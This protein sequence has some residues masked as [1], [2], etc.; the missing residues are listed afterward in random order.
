[1]GPQKSKPEG[2]IPIHRGYEKLIS[3]Q[4]AEIIYDGT[5][6]CDKALQLCGKAFSFVGVRRL[7]L[8]T[9]T[10]RT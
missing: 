4:N 6:Y 9:P 2:F 8:P 10:S 5:K 1:M 3:Y 7:E